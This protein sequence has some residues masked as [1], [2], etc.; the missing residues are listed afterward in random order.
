MIHRSYYIHEMKQTI[1]QTKVHEMKQN[2][3]KEKLYVCPTCDKTFIS[4]QYMFYKTH[5]FMSCI[6]FLPE[7]SVASVKTAK[8]VKQKGLNYSNDFT[9]ME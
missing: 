9:H 7:L 6:P 8:S 4:S 5:C 1:Y 2:T 3:Q